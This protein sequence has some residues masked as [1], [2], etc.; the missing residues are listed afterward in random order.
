MNGYQILAGCYVVV[1]ILMTYRHEVLFAYVL[2]LLLVSVERWRAHRSVEAG[3]FCAT[4]FV[5]LFC[6]GPLMGPSGLETF[7]LTIFAGLLW[8]NQTREM[9]PWKRSGP[10]SADEAPKGSS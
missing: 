2:G 1:G 5:V 8:G 6:L 9:K 10:Q 3:V 7:L 4:T